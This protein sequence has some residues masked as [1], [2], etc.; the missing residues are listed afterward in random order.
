MGVTTALHPGP[1]WGLIALWYQRKL[2]GES[3]KVALYRSEADWKSTVF[4]LALQFLARR[5]GQAARNKLK[6]SDLTQGRIRHGLD[7]GFYFP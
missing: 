5:T 3:H 7:S 1:A 2:P 6:Q 4:E